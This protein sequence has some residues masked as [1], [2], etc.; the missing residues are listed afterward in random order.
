MLKWALGSDRS[1][2]RARGEKNKT[3]KNLTLKGESLL[4]SW[5]VVMISAGFGT[6]RIEPNF[7]PDCVATLEPHGNRSFDERVKLP[8]PGQ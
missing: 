3:K 6:V 2:A 4:P 5:W 8:M 1:F 7:R